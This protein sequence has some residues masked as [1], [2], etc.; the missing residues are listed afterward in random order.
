M[1]E[2]PV[3][4]ETTPAAPAAPA[5]PASPATPPEPE[6]SVPYSRLQEVI[7]KANTQATELEELRTKERQRVEQEQLARGEHQKIIDELRPQAGRAAE[8]EA[9]LNTVVASEIEAIPED[10]RSLVP[11]LA[12]EKKLA[13]IVANRA[14]LMNTKPLNSNHPLNPGG[15]DAGGSKQIFTSAQIKDAK[16]YEANRDAI[17]LAQKEGRI[18]D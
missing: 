2:T 17:L 5:S 11:D 14:F 8:L 16:F 1:A 3:V 10:R 4:P 18:R 15:N 12:P 7:L 13:W 6:K 9:A